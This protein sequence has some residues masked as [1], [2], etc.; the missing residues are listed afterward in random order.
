M[1]PL[2]SK[3]LGGKETQE[4]QAIST[5]DSV[6]KHQRVSIIG[7]IAN[8]LGQLAK[9]ECCNSGR[10][11]I[12][13]LNKDLNN[14]NLDNQEDYLL[15][16][17]DCLVTWVENNE[18]VY[19]N[20]KMMR[21]EANYHKYLLEIYELIK[22]DDNIYF[23][24]KAPNAKE[25]SME[26]RVWE[27][28][29]DVLHA[30]SQRKFLLIKENELEM[31]KIGRTLCN[32]P[33]IEKN[34]IPKVRNKAKECL[35]NIGIQRS[36]VSS[37][38]LIISEAITNILKHAKD[39]RLVIIQAEKSLNVIIEDKGNGFPLEILPYTI[40][41]EGYSTKK[42]LGQGFTLMLKLAKRVLLKTSST[43]SSIVLVLKSE[44]GE[45]D[46]TK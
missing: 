42:S 35:E 9:V 15:Y 17:A 5:I 18:D 8:K 29:R 43:G 44:E 1:N 40:L 7:W 46:G 25:L 19:F 38:I 31:Y 12:N 10:L 34:D 14:L 4:I 32:E 24:K 27:V 11:I 20:I 30:T 6:Q 13:A 33:V 28:Y 23:N 45:K 37:Y 2:L 22:S 3:L 41:T 39:G 21:L 16:L 26:D 36:E